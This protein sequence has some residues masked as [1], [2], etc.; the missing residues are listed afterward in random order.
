MLSALSALSVAKIFHQAS[1]SSFRAEN[2]QQRESL[3]LCVRMR[4]YM[5]AQRKEFLAGSG[6]KPSVRD[7]RAS[8]TKSVNT[9]IFQ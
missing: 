5:A 9:S 6:V 8:P 1:F 2:V 7:Y 4:Q 3:A